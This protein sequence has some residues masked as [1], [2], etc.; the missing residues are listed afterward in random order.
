VPVTYRL[1]GANRLIYT[2]CTGPVT[3]AE[4]VDH[5]RVLEQDPCCPDHVDV[6]LEV[7]DG[8]TVPKSNELQQVTR[9]IERIRGRVQFGTCAIVAPTDVLFG[10]MRMFEVFAEAYFDETQVFR[11]CG[12]AEVWLA[13]KRHGQRAAQTP[14][15]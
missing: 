8:T 6:L 3:V 11:T 10:K 5:F 2:T 9:A 4:V 7:K 1:D 15:V 12:E 14:A 13:S